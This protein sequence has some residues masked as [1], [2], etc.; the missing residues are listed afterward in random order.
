MSKQLTAYSREGYSRG[1]LTRTHNPQIIRGKLGGSKS[2]GR[3]YSESLQTLSDLL[4]SYNLNR[5]QVRMISMTRKPAEAITKKNT[6]ILLACSMKT[7][8]RTINETN[9]F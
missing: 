4:Y 2:D 9:N 8:L 5:G 7:G 3:L 1:I 6:K